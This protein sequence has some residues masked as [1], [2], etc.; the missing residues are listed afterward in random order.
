[1]WRP[2]LPT[3]MRSPSRTAARGGSALGVDIFSRLHRHAIGGCNVG[4]PESRR[5]FG[6]MK[7]LFDCDP[8]RVPIVFRHGETPHAP[9]PSRIAVSPPLTPVSDSNV[10]CDC[11]A[12]VRPAKMAALIASHAAAWSAIAAS[13]SAKKRRAPCASRLSTAWKARTASRARRAAASRLS[14]NSV[15]DS[16]LNPPV[17]HRPATMAQP[18]LAVT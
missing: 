7:R 16:T 1:M 3:R 18:Y 11:F 5:R 13:R 15:R 10:V 8:E 9:S 2:M 14:C 6:P 17:E 4:R 12:H